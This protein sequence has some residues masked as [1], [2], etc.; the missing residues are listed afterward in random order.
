MTQ[1]DRTKTLQELDGQRRE[2]PQ[3]ASHAAAECHRLRG[4]PLRDF[5]VE[6]LRL[7]VAQNE[8]LGY[9]MPLAL[10]SLRKEPLMECVFFRGDFLVTVLRSEDDFWRANSG[11]HAEVLAIADR[12]FTELRS[13]SESDR[14]L[15]EDDLI[16]AC[17]SF[18]AVTQSAH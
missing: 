12:A 16:E 17:K 5:T 18:Q 8:S 15:V 14:E 2:E 4:V 10:E 1:F 7:M 13:W 11:L 3:F 9:V 6:D